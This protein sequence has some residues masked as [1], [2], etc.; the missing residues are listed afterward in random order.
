MAT[1]AQFFE[2]GPFFIGGNIV[3]DYKLYHYVAGTTSLL[4]LWTDRAKSSATA[5]PLLADA[6]GLFSAYGDG[7]YKFVLKTAAETTVYTWDNVSIIDQ[8][9]IGEGAALASAATLVLGTDGNFFHVT[10]T[11]EISAISGNIHRVTLIFDDILNLAH[12][13]NLFL[14]GAID[15]LTEANEV[16]EF[17]N[18]GAGVWREIAITIGQNVIDI[19]IKKAI[20]RLR[21]IDT[22]DGQEYDVAVSGGDLGLQENT[23][24]EGAPSWTNIAYYDKSLATWNLVGQTVLTPTI[25]TFANALHGHVN[26]AGGGL[27][28]ANTVGVTQVK[29]ASTGT[30]L[31]ANFTGTA[32]TVQEFTVTGTR[33][34][35]FTITPD[36]GIGNITLTPWAPAN[37]GSAHVG[38]WQMTVDNTGADGGG[39]SQV[40]VSWNILGTV[41]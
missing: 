41:T 15:H 7:L 39:S 12:S 25:A 21:L 33:I 37:S 29:V 22:T 38:K 23:G 17:I 11:T 14:N 6:N 36:A 5:Q 2:R 18:D 35:D 28:G 26:A 3:T 8:D 27:L 4:N 1:F 40:T 20:P 10:G 31:S 32:G 34:G 19:K 13:G 30:W 24:T 16:K 9:V